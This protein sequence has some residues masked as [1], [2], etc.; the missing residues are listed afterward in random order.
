[1]DLP[2]VYHGFTIDLPWIYH[3]FTID[4]PWIYHWF[5]MDLPLIY[6]VLPIKKM[7]IFDG[8]CPAPDGSGWIPGGLGP[9]TPGMRALDQQIDGPGPG[10]SSPGDGYCELKIWDITKQ[11]GY[12][13][14]DLMGFNGI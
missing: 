6:H 2:L 4:L 14:W 5:T 3:G 9:Q 12:N 7:M 10:E 1:M 11:M 13:K 8:E